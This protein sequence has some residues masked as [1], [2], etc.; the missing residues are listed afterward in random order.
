M[1]KQ[2]ILMGFLLLGQV[3]P[4]VKAQN[5]AP[6]TADLKSLIESVEKKF[7]YS[8]MFS[9]TDV[10]INRPIAYDA[11]A[12]N[13]ETLLQRAFGSTD[14]GYEISGK[15][16]LLTRKA[17]A[18][19][20]RQVSGRVSDGRG[21]PLPGVNIRARGSNKHTV[22]DHLGHFV[23]EVRASDVLEVRHVGFAPQDVPVLAG[24]PVAIALLPGH[25]ELEEV[26]V[27]GYG[28]L[29]RSDVTG[30]ITAIDT[31]EL[32][33]RATAS[34]AEAL[35]GAAA[36]VN[37]QKNSGVAGDGVQIKIRG[38]NTFGSNEPLYVI[39]GFPGAIDNISPN[40]IASME[41]LKDGAAAAIYGSVAANGVVIVTTKAGRTGKVLVDINSFANA[42]RTANRLEVLDADGYV[43][44]HRRMYE[45]YNKY[46]STPVALP[47]YIAN[48]GRNN[49]DWQDE[50]FRNGLSTANSLA[51]R[52]GQQDT[53]YSLSANLGN[54]KGVVIANRFKKENVRMKL[55]TKKS[56]FSAEGNMAYTSAKLES[57]N[58]S[59]KEVYMISPLAAVY[60]DA[61]PGGFGL[62]NWGG[63]PNN[64]NVVADEHFRTSWSKKQ[65]FAGSAF[66]NA[67]LAKGLDFRTGYAF[68]GINTQEYYHYPP[69]VADEKNPFE[70][71][72]YSEGRS[73]WQEQ[74]FDNLLTFRA[75][76]GKHRINA[77]LGTSLNLQTSNWNNIGVEGKKIVYSVGNGALV[78]SESAEGFLDPNFMT[79]NAGRGGTFTADGSKYDYNRMSYFGRVNYAYADR[80]LVQLTL[81]RDGSSKFGR[82]SRYGNFP[83][84]AL[85]WKIDEE[86]FFPKDGFVHRLKLRGSWG[87]LGNEVALGYYDHQA[88]ISTFNTLRMGYVRGSGN[89]WPGSVAMGLENRLLSW[90]TTVSQNIGIDFGL[91]SGRVQG[92]LN[93]FSNTTEDLLITKKIAPSAG[94]LD[95]TL[96]VGKIRNSGFELELKYGSADRPFRYDVGLNVS[97]LRNKVLAL[98]NEDQILLGGGLKFGTEHFPNQTRTGHPIGAFFL[99]RAEGIFQDMDEV[100][101]HADQN[102]ALLQPNA[103]PG[104]IRFLD[105]DGNGAID[106]DDKEY[107]G[108][109]IPRLEAG[110]NLSA[111]YKGFDI[112]ALIGSGWG[113]KL[114]NGNRYF[115]EAMNSGANF[116]TTTLDAWTENNRNT[117]IPRAVL[118]DPNGNSRESTRFLEPGD[119]VRL[120]QLQLGYTLPQRALGAIRSENLR[121]Y[122]SGQNLFTWTKYSGIDPEFSP[123]ANGGTPSVLNTG[124]DRYIFPFTKSYSLGLQ[125]TF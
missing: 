102:G 12:E 43:A 57:P 101:R 40:D 39:D 29:R 44:V 88:L 8:F 110:L 124:V 89:P 85:G 17:R 11:D 100:N 24:R 71:P 97:T 38:V 74:I 114:Y 7:G 10:D 108:T 18:A 117:D 94:L 54:D 52:G 98:A 91:F 31:D 72:Y 34:P 28:T 65:D 27:I 116:L 120:R 15:R 35:Q 4:A 73:Y 53:R 112:S 6:G 49:T 125:F 87:R 66:V 1:I 121:L 41:V 81:R 119:F 3:L 45:E 107:A 111:S 14:V 118:Q 2:T 99:Y 46:A 13:V 59:L 55:G 122:I 26:V 76:I 106:D 84:L 80:Y 22:T 30:A 5:A 86:G 82:D 103:R 69:F 48:P 123:S 96:N 32:A 78:T 70:Y 93:Y 36:G 56:I 92:A 109:G 62:T 105:L 60:D 23:V 83:S 79:I 90:E 50:V 64:V 47:D 67:E 95:P 115:F 58:F 20:S 21:E 68:S 104:D 9:N 42:T 19:Q 33:K 63:L 51:L 16:I 25:E 77:L 113:H 75:D 37:V 61:Q